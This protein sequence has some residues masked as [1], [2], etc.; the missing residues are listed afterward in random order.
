MS[1]HDLTATAVL[2]GGAQLA[3]EEEIAEFARLLNQGASQHQMFPGLCTEQPLAADGFG[4]FWWVLLPSGARDGTDARAFIDSARQG[5][6]RRA[7][8]LKLPV[9]ELD[10]AG[11]PP[12]AP[13]E[14]TAAPYLAFALEEGGAEGFSWLQRHAAMSRRWRHRAH[15]PVKTASGHAVAAVAVDEPA[16]QRLIGWV[17]GGVT[18]RTVP[19]RAPA[20]RP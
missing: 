12:E 18:V 4:Q 16:D 2:A 6:R 13:A 5:L 10:L 8:E 17:P 14:T 7:E 1:E 19:W 9:A 3:G 20:Y 15:G 11:L